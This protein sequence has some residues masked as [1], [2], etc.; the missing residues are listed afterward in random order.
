MLTAFGTL[1]SLPHAS[2]QN[3]PDRATLAIHA[4]Q[5]YCYDGTHVVTFNHHGLLHEATAQ[6]GRINGS[7]ISH[8][9]WT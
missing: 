1:S 5:C 4:D 2:G 8:H 6:L 3:Q 9:C 7:G